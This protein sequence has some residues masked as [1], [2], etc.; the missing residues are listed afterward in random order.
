MGAAE[1]DAGV[2][3]VAGA[4]AGEG[5]ETFFSVNIAS[6]A[7]RFGAIAGLGTTGVGVEGAERGVG[8]EGAT[9][10]AAAGAAGVGIGVAAGGTTGLGVDEG[11]TTED[12]GAERVVAGTGAA[13]AGLG[14]YDRAPGIPAPEGCPIDARIFEKSCSLMSAAIA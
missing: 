14:A 2:V 8:A 6:A 11:I 9:E 3:G 12:W 1:A 7:P 5:G 4:T 10:A 13:G